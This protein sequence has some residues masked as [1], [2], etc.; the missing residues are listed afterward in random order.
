MPGSPPTRYH[1]WFINLLIWGPFLVD[2]GGMSCISSCI[3]ISSYIYILSDITPAIFISTVS[4]CWMMSNSPG[5]RRRRDLCMARQAVQF[6][7]DRTPWFQ[8]SGKSRGHWAKSLATTQLEWQQ[9]EQRSQRVLALLER[10]RIDG[11]FFWNMG[12]TNMSPDV[13]SGSKIG[14][15]HS[16]D[17]EKPWFWIE[18]VT[19]KHTL[20]WTNLTMENHHAI[21]GKIHYF[22]GNFQ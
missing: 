9:G 6:R 22:N 16:K 14:W 1:G 20:R 12:E 3:S 21:N 2:L 4:G 17:V 19:K 8:F 11:R 7:D 5:W 10:S 15:C 18:D 13:E